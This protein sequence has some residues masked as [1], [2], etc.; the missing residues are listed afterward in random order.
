MY[1]RP[2][3]YHLHAVS[4]GIIAVCVAT[5]GCSKPNPQEVI[6]GNWKIR[7]EWIAVEEAKPV[8][9]F[10]SAEDVKRI[11]TFNRSMAL[12]VKPDNTFILTMGA[13][14]DGTW[15][16]SE[17]KIVLTFSADVINR[18]GRGLPSTTL[19][20][21]LDRKTGHLDIPIPNTPGSAPADDRTIS[22]AKSAK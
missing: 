19:T 6:Y 18:S 15:T 13:P 21:H 16:F 8:D 1:S 7:P 3:T 11:N 9:S 12:L 22:L 14:M 2:F 5:A 4:A 10:F 20:G 17:D